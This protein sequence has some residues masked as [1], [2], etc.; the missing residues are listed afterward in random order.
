MHTDFTAGEQHK[1]NILSALIHVCV[2]LRSTAYTKSFTNQVWEI[3]AWLISCLVNTSVPHG[4]VQHHPW[5]TDVF[6]RKL[7]SYARISHTQIVKDFV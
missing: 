7:I 1:V 4:P 5:G 6:T 3:L 2:L